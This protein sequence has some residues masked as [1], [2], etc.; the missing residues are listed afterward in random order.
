MNEWGQGGWEARCLLSLP[1]APPI[2]EHKARRRESPHQGCASPRSTDRL[3]LGRLSPRALEATQGGRAGT[4]QEAS[5]R[6]CLSVEKRSRPL[7]PVPLRD[8][9]VGTVGKCVITG[10]S[11]PWVLCLPFSPWAAHACL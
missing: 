8:T 5:G 11:Y 4:H 3:A 2:S 6:S 1:C 9:L 10:W 7:Q